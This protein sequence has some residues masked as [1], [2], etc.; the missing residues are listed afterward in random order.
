M[1]L[2]DRSAALRV[3]RTFLDLLFAQIPA[4]QEGQ[5]D[6]EDDC[7]T[8]LTL[9]DGREFDFDALILALLAYDDDSRLGLPHLQNGEQHDLNEIVEALR[10]LVD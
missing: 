5:S 9:P 6:P 7:A 8:T 2:L 4:P 10:G 1:P 3:A